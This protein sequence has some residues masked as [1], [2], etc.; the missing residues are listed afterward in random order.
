MEQM[1]SIKAPGYHPWMQPVYHHPGPAESC[2]LK[3]ICVSL[4][5]IA[6]REGG[7]AELYGPSIQF[8][9]GSSIHSL[10]KSILYIFFLNL[11]AVSS[12]IKLSGVY[13]SVC[14]PLISLAQ[15][16]LFYKCQNLSPPWSLLIWEAVFKMGFV[17]AFGSSL[18]WS[19]VLPGFFWPLSIV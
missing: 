18:L 16:M 2:P 6:D 13:S 4:W 10:W 17:C 8:M 11:A 3:R 9:S 1:H 12:A 5:A 7:A 14:A 19:L 15:F